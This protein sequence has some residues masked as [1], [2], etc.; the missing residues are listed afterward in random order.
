[1]CF[2]LPSI[3][4]PTGL[5]FLFSMPKFGSYEGST[6]GK[7]HMKVAPATC[8]LM[9]LST[10]W[11]VGRGDNSCSKDTV[12]F[13]NRVKDPSFQMEMNSSFP[14]DWLLLKWWVSRLLACSGMIGGSM[15]DLWD[16][17]SGQCKTFDCQT[18]RKWDVS[19]LGLYFFHGRFGDQSC[20]W[21]V[22]WPI[23]LSSVGVKE[24]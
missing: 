15:K 9:L 21:Q 5:G 8:I 18:Y 19:N 24:Q 2:S 4:S 14:W 13:L 3:S 23:L 11:G 6:V 17:L 22:W 7:S 20:S 1:M 10:G 12:S 16:H